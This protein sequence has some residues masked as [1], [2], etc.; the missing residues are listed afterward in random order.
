M[1]VE[2]NAV[3]AAPPVSRRPVPGKRRVQAS[4]GFVPVD[5]A[6][7]WRFRELLYRLMWRDAKGRYKQTF[8]GPIWAILRPLVTMIVMAAVFGGLAGFESGTDVPYPLFLYTG[9]LIWTYFSSAITGST[10]S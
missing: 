6:E 3:S 7:I 8:L 1:S 9:I 4:R 2:E 10:S 5:F